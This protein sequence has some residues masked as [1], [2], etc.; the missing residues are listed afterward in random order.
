MTSQ[1]MPAAHENSLA[2]LKVLVWLAV[3]AVV[4]SASA[5]LMF[6]IIDTAANSTTEAALGIT[7][8]IS[9]ITVGVLAVAAFIY[10]QAKKLWQFAPVWLTKRST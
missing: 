4:V 9:G 10:A 8:A 2:R 7:A 6:L 1:T 5:G 3:A